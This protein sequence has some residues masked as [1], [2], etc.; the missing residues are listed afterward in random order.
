M[1]RGV[2]GEFNIIHM[3]QDFSD[4]A[5]Y[6]SWEALDSIEMMPHI[7]LGL[8]EPG[9]STLRTCMLLMLFDIFCSRALV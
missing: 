3:Y 8:L 9:E 2:Y 1:H 7:L 4:F 5:L 6:G